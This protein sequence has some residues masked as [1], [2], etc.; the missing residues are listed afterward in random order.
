MKKLIITTI[1]LLSISNAFTQESEKNSA[2]FNL[3]EGIS[4]SFNEEKYEFNIFGFIRPSYIYSDEK[5]Y[6]SEGSYSNVYRQFKSQNS[7]LYFTGAAIDEKLSFTIQMDYSSS[8]PL[9]EAFIGYHINDKTT[10]YF[11][12]MQVSHNNLEM[13][14]NEN[15]LRFT[16][17]GLISQT[18]TESGEE[19]GL[20]LETSFG[21]SFLVEPTLAITSGDGKNSFGEDSR[22][23]DKGGVKFGSRINILPF[24]DFSEG[25]RQSTVDL[26]HEEKPKVQIGIAYS[27]NIGASNL[28]GDGHGDFVLY[29]SSGEENFPDYSQLFFDLNLK[30][31]GFSLLFEYADSYASGLDDIYTDPNGFNTLVPKQI[32]E[33]LVLGDSQGIHFGYFTKSGYSIDFIYEQSNPEFNSNIDSILRESTN[34][35]FGLSKYLSD[36]NI[37]LQASVFKTNLK[38]SFVTQDDEFMNASFVVTLVF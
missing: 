2:S 19:F 16:S 24:G 18:Y 14:Q 3:G 29:D 23:S 30:Y 34:V 9:V 28:V 13:V 31:K 5:I 4:F 15:D 36:N 7:N 32:S 26:I 21:N 20:F 10:L 8:D 27:K 25:N 11:G 12:Q 22:D 37:K 1:F 17:R 38:N 6:T 35:G 33:Y